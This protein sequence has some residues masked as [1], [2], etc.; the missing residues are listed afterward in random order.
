MKRT[1]LEALNLS[2][3][4]IDSIMNL[5]QQDEESHKTSVS[6]KDTEI[7]QLK[8]ELESSKNQIQELQT[9]IGDA[10]DLKTLKEQS[11]AEKEAYEKKIEELQRSN[12]TDKFFANYKF[13]SELAKSAAIAEFNKKELKLEDGKFL[14]AEDFMKQLQTENP[15]AFTAEGSDK[16]GVHIDGLKDG[17]NNPG[18]ASVTLPLTC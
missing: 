12:A 18:G 17:D 1:D 2:K 4:T 3:E 9:K 5:H 8:S 7:A 13:T 16:E 11:K 15:A 10:E 14:G 6:A